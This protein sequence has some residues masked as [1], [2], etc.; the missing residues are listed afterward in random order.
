M[1]EH[2]VSSLAFSMITLF[3]GWLIKGVYSLSRE[4]PQMEKRIIEQ[5]GKM[6]DR[7]KEESILSHRRHNI[8]DRIVSKITADDFDS[9]QIAEGKA[10]IPPINPKLSK[11][12]HGGSE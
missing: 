11:V 3:L 4:I 10:E 1:P 2:F 12:M 5:V 7:E 9:R 8:A 6:V